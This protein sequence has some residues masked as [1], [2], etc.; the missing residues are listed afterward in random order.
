MWNLRAQID[1][2]LLRYLK[3]N[4]KTFMP[5]DFKMMVQC[6]PVEP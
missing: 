4:L 1:S 6:G 2:G 5:W 3:A